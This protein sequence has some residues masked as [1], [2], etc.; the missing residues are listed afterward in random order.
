MSLGRSKQNGLKCG[1]KAPSAPHSLRHWQCCGR[2]TTQVAA[3]DAVVRRHDGSANDSHLGPAQPMRHVQR[4]R[5]GLW[6]PRPLQLEAVPSIRE[7]GRDGR[8]RGQRREPDA[9]ADG[10]AVTKLNFGS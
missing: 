1:V 2:R 10:I 6:V 3:G 7:A 9:S 5:T 4:P 8:P